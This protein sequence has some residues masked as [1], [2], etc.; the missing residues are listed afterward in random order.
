MRMTSTIIATALCA[1]LQLVRGEANYG[2]P[3]GGCTIVSQY[4]NGRIGNG[5]DAHM[6]VCHENEHEDPFG[7]G[8]DGG[9]RIVWGNLGPTIDGRVTPKRVWLAKDGTE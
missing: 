7:F 3:A 1:W 2:P 6:A 5:L 8:D 9:H 4:Q